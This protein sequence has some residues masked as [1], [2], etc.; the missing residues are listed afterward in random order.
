MN[1]NKKIK[2]ERLKRIRAIQDRLGFRPEEWQR[3]QW[4]QQTSGAGAEMST[5]AAYPRLD[6]TA[7]QEDLQVHEA[8]QVCAYKV[9]IS[10]IVR[11]NRV[12]GQ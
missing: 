6:R 11:A 1:F 5:S 3:G 9:S 4:A 12:L 2:E 7:T 10:T 8:S